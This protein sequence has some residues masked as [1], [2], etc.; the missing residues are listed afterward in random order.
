VVSL[1][2][3]LLTGSAI[4]SGIL[5]IRSDEAA[6]ARRLSVVDRGIALYASPALDADR[7][8]RADAGD[9]AHTLSSQ[10]V[11]SRVRL[12]GDR[13]GWVESVRLIPLERR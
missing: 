2:T 5:A 11:W 1:L 8:A 6:A 7:V 10:G 9:I 4:A 3:G 13:E 12:D